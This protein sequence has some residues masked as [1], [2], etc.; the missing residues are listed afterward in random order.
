MTGVKAHRRHRDQAASRVAG[1]RTSRP[2]GSVAALVLAA[3]CLATLGVL[4]AEHVHAAPFNIMTMGDSRTHGVNTVEPNLFNVTDHNVTGLNSDGTDDPTDD[5]DDLGGYRVPLWQRLKDNGFDP[6]MVGSQTQSHNQGGVPDNNSVFVPDGSNSDN[7]AHEGHSSWRIGGTYTDGSVSGGSFPDNGDAT[8]GGVPSNWVGAD[9]ADGNGSAGRG[10]IEHIDEIFDPNISVDP[11]TSDRPGTDPASVD[12]VVL[13][14]GIN[15]IKNDEDPDTAPSR[16]IQLI[17]ELNTFV[18]H[19]EILVLNQSYVSDTSAAES[20]GG[21]TLTSYP[22]GD[23][24]TV[25]SAIDTFN[26]DFATLFDQQNYSNASLVDINNAIEA[27]RA[28]VGDDTLVF[29]DGLHYTDPAYQ[30]VGEYLAD[31]IALTVIPE[32]GVLALALLGGGLTLTRRDRR[33]PS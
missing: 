10:L 21:S 17:D 8:N 22:L 28:Q 13:W 19:A 14:I 30:F 33:A 12:L 18:S 7:W 16:L 11:S 27:Y 20:M 29:G 4:G 1:Y 15:D 24:A 3:A 31:E 32:P 9:T 26:S 5:D 25:N 6:K 23:V 2:R